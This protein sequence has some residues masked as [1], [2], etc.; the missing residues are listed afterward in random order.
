MKALILAAGYATRLYPLTRQYPKPL[1]EIKGKPIINYI[2]EKLGSVR[3]LDEVYIVTNNKFIGIFRRWMK[4]FKS[5]KK[6]TLVNDLTRSN[7]DRLGSIGDIDFVI[8]KKKLDDDLLVIGGDNLFNGSLKGFLSSAL[9]NKSS[10][11]MGVYRLQQKKDASRYGVVRLD[12]R[13]RIACFKEKPSRPQS[14]L[15]A[16]CLYFIPRACLGL[17]GEYIRNSRDKIDAAGSYI[18]WLKD[19]AD[20]YGYVFEGFW[21][22][23]GDH[24]YLNAAKEKL[25]N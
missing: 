8:G 17:V 9:K 16:M 13:G 14:N 7:R 3:G 1:L 23:I 22:D 24:K 18:A 21:F 10:V 11:S 12:K 19:R 20:V 15:V 5:S 25:A 2:V 4:T 6:I